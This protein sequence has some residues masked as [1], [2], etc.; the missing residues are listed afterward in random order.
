MG[1]MAEC[2]KVRK[3]CSE[4]R[5]ECERCARIRIPCEVN[6]IIQGRVDLVVRNRSFVPPRITSPYPKEEFGTMHS[7]LMFRK[8]QFEPTV[9][10]TNDKSRSRQKCE[11]FRNL[12][13]YKRI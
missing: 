7:R 6:I 4:R 8:G 3:K 2:R 1:I 9:W 10:R 11:F 5:P 12:H 13:S